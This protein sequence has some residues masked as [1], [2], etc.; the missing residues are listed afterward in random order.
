VRN[1]SLDN[2]KLGKA[3]MA[4]QRQAII[5]TGAASGIG[6][7]TA[8]AFAAR[9]WFVGGFDIDA[10]GLASLETELGRGAGMF[11]PLNIADRPAVEAVMKLFGDAADGR[12]DI[13][14]SNAG[15]DAK[16][17][18]ADMV[19]ERIVNVVNVNLLGSLAV[20]QTAIPLLRATENSLCLSTASA[21]AI[22]G[23]ANLAVYSATKHAVRGL[24]E[25]LSVELAGDGIRVADILPGIVNTGMLP[26]QVKA[27]L[28]T[29]GLWRALPA[30]TI[31]ETVWD[32]YHGEKLHWYVPEELAV[33]DVEATTY[34]ERL[35][36]ARRSGAQV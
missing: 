14:F 3:T 12:L 29:E 27:Q 13:L 9:G 22:F 32:A 23:T 34:P 1:M 33:F 7:A 8:R 24:T 11:Q 10:S 18:F 15:I 26:P 36:D 35:R 31:A 6:R 21:S 19:W 16:G 20:I 2:P 28:P 25:A 5:V 17:T 30:E 4:S